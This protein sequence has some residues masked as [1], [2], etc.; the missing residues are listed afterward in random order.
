[1]VLYNAPYQKMHIELGKELAELSKKK[2]LT[3]RKAIREVTRWQNA[4][5]FRSVV[6]WILEASNG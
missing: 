6:K 2:R 3:V 5:T 4:D 1:M